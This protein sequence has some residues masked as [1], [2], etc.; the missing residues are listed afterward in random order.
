MSPTSY[1]AAPPRID[2]RLAP[3]RESGTSRP[4]HCPEIAPVQGA[5]S[6]FPA[7]HRVKRT[8]SEISVEP[9]SYSG[10]LVAQGAPGLTHLRSGSDRG[11]HGGRCTGCIDRRQRRGA[12]IAKRFMVP[13]AGLE[14]ARLAPLP[15][16][17]SVSTNSTTWA[18]LRVFAVPPANPPRPCRPLPAAPRGPPCSPPPP[19]QPVSRHHRCLRHPLPEPRCRRERFPES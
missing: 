6:I 9:V 5:R 17:D 12:E 7:W 13:K 4:F 10:S 11:Q 14:P 19:V 3:F 8:C 2:K 16:Q 1:Q 18:K 15:P